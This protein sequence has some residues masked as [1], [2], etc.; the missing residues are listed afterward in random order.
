MNFFN[1]N[2]LSSEEKSELF[3]QQRKFLTKDH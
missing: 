1:K 2:W 3:R